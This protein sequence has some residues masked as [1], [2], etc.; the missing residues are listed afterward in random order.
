M[1]FLF[2]GPSLVGVGFGL[3]DCGN[4]GTSDGI[5]AS[6]TSRETPYTAIATFGTIPSVVIASTLIVL[7]GIDIMLCNMMKRNLGYSPKSPFM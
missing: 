6:T 1:R 2:L 5:S 3:G 7:V 4:F